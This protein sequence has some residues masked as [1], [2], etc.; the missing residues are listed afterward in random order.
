[1]TFSLPLWAAALCSCLP[2]FLTI[3]V[4]ILA[5]LL[6]QSV[7]GAIGVETS[8][9]I[10]LAMGQLVLPWDVLI[11][12]ARVSPSLAV[13]NSSTIAN[14]HVQYFLDSHHTLK[15]CLLVWSSGCCFL[16][17]CGIL[18][19]KLSIYMSSV[20][21]TDSEGRLVTELSV[22]HQLCCRK[23]GQSSLVLQLLCVADPMTM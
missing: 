11:L 4:S 20:L 13:I 16:W 21:E 17:F 9:G 23:L 6:G 18:W 12:T 10:N 22:I 8:S 7:S 19:G 3:C 5:T 15:Q 1:M 14:F 2:I